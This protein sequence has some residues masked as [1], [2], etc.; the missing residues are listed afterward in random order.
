MALA[1]ILGALFVRFRDLNYIWEVL[2]QAAFY[3]TPILYPLTM[4]PTSV[5]QAADP[6]PGGPA[7]AG[8]PLRAGHAG[9]ADHHAALRHA[10][11]PCRPPRDHL[12]LAVSSVV[13]FKR[14]SRYFAE[15]A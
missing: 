7:P 14:Q 12:V 5:G 11:G 3:A 10:V 13:Y 6:E 9:D 1:F 2:M 15:E 4:V 8:R